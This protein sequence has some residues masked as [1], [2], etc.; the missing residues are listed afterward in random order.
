VL[1][2]DQDPA[3]V[4]CLSFNRADWSV[5]VED[6]TPKRGEWVQLHVEYT[7]QFDPLIRLQINQSGQRAGLGGSA[8]LWDDVTVER[9]MGEIKLADGIRIN[10]YVLDGLDVTPAGGMTVRVAPGKI[11]VDG[12]TVEVK[13]ETVLEVPRPRLLQVRDEQGTLSDQVPQSYNGGSALRECLIE[14]GIGLANALVGD[15]LALKAEPGPDGRRFEEGKDWR[16]DRLW[17]RIGRLPDGAIGADTQ[18]YVDYDWGLT[19]VDTLEVCSDGTLRLCQ[20]AER[21]TA[22]VPPGTDAHARALCNVYLPP[23]AAEITQDLIY[24]IGLPFPAASAE[25]TRRNAALIPRT[26]EKLNRGDKVTVV[27]W[28]DSVTCGGTS[29]TPEKAFPQSFTAWLRNKYTKADIE[30]VNAGTG[31]WSTWN[32]LPLFE[33]EVMVH[34]PDLMVIEF[35]NDM[36]MDRETV[37]KH[38]TQAVNRVREGGGEVIILTPHFVRPDWMGTGDMRTPET[39]ATV[40]Y[41]KEFAADNQVG[42]A[43]ASRRWAHLWIEGIPYLTLEYNTINHPDDRGHQLFVEELQR[44]FP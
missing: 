29:S 12:R 39:R 44:F 34:K 30:Y 23:A 13:Q 42:I 20:G 16:A 2:P 7:C 9:E 35:V 8:L 24:P 3:P 18:V 31:G 33:Q 5:L 10:P 17:A 28:G 15:S 26:L 25:E 14:G 40:G 21:M 19:R 36:G 32:K 6:T 11:D 1:V 38:Y 27:F 41:L 4:P 22:P 43:D 37:Y